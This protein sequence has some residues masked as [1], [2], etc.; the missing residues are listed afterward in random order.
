[1]QKPKKNTTFIRR[2]TLLLTVLLVFYPMVTMA[3]TFLEIQKWLQAHNDYR[4]SHG[5]PAVTWSETLA[6]SAQSYANTCPSGHSSSGYGENLA[7]ATYGMEVSL[8]VTMW[9]DEEAFYDYNNPGFN[10]ETGHFTQV[11]WK[12]TIEIGCGLA[13]NCSA[14][15]PYMAH[16]WVCQYNPPGNYTNLFAE[17]VFPPKTDNGDKELSASKGKTTPILSILLLQ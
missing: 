3:A 11:V 4:A 9:Y 16:V 13:T 15:S 1:M 5:V 17:N 7:W 2:I 12:D 10:S 14:D 6:T 8:V